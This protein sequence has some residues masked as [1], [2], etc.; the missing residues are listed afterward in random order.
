MEFPPISLAK[1]NNHVTV[2]FISCPTGV[3][4]F[5]CHNRRVCLFR[6][7]FDGVGC[8]TVRRRSSPSAS[9]H[10]Q[11]DLLRPKTTT[12]KEVQEKSL[13]R[14]LDVHH[15][16]LSTFNLMYCLCRCPRSTSG[17]FNPVFRSSSTRGSPRLGAAHI[18]KPTFVESSAT[19]ACKP[20]FSSAAT[21]QSGALK[22]SRA[23]P[24]VSPLWI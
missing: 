5:M 20:L 24:E 7:R 22:P 14:R 23:A 9:G 1:C 13:T 11:F 4:W 19:Q 18:S 16:L 3:G 15:V 6:G 10:W 17:Q 8:V 12:R 2:T 21:P